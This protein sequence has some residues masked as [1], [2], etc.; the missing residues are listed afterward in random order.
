[1][2]SEYELLDELAR[3]LAQPDIT[4]DEVTA[5]MVA[6]YSGVSWSTA[7]RTLK[8]KEAAGVLV[9]RRVR[10]PNGRTALAYRRA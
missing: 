1:M 7:A 2:M 4:Q 10:I 6:D 5:Q 9:S 3:E 8:D